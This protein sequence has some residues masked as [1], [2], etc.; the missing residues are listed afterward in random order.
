MTAFGVKRTST[1]PS[2]LALRPEG[3]H[4]GTN[5]GVY[6]LVPAES[7]EYKHNF[8]YVVPGGPTTY[9]SFP[10]GKRTFYERWPT[11]PVTDNPRC[12]IGASVV[13]TGDIA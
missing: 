2:A 7:L 11:I 10:G 3:Q 9:V 13:T 5:V 12:G 8:L 1:L 6:V 4:V